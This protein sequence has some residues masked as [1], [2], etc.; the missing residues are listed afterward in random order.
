MKPPAT[1]TPEGDSLRNDIRRTDRLVVGARQF[2]PLRIPLRDRGH[3]EGR[4]RPGAVIVSRV[5]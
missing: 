2:V 3:Q 1:T 5:A 4:S